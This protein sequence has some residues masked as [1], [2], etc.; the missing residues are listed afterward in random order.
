MEPAFHEAVLPGTGFRAGAECYLQSFAQ[1]LVLVAQVLTTLVAMQDGRHRVPAQGIQEGRVRQ[2]ARMSQSKLPAKYASGF[3]V[4]HDR[5]VM[6]L[7]VN[8]QMGEVLHPRRGINH[9][10]VVHAILWPCFIPEHSVWSEC[11]VGS[12]NLWFSAFAT[13]LLASWRNGYARQS[14][15]PPGFVLTPLKFSSK[16]TDTVAGMLLVSL[17]KFAYCESISLSTD[18][19]CSVQPTAG[20]TQDSCALLAPSR[21]DYFQDG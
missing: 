15:N 10:T 18:G 14:A 2:I 5:K 12:C 9:T 20:N 7:A 6:P 4:E 8:P 21:V 3:E 16:P 1:I 13:V 11:I 19:G 17:Q